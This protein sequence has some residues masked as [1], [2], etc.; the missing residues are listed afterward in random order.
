MGNLLS[1][2]LGKNLSVNVKLNVVLCLL[3]LNNSQLNEVIKHQSIP[4]VSKYKLQHFL[5]T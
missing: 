2:R 5:H 4:K 3:S 1:K